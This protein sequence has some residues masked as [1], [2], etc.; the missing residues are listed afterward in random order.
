MKLNPEKTYFLQKLGAKNKSSL[1]YKDSFD[2]IKGNVVLISN[3]RAEWMIIT[4]VRGD[5]YKTSP[6]LKSQQKGKVIQFET[7]N[8]FY[9]LSEL[10]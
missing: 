3:G 1:G 4:H 9:K 8:S 2:I 5:W 6:I 7:E 10:K